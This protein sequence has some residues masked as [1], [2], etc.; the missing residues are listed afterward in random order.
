MRLLRRGGRRA[1][2][3]ETFAETNIPRARFGVLYLSR[4]MFHRVALTGDARD[5]ADAGSGEPGR[6]GQ[7][8]R[9][10]DAQEGGVK[11]VRRSGRAT[12]PRGRLAIRGASRARRRVEDIAAFETLFKALADRTRLRILGLLAGGGEVCVCDI[13]ESLRI[14]Q[15]RASRHLAYLRR[16][17]LVEARRRG[18]WVHYRLAPLADTVAATMLQMIAHGLGHL[19][20]VVLDRQRLERR[21]GC[22]PPLGAAPPGGLP[23]CGPLSSE[24]TLAGT[25]AAPPAPSP[26]SSPAASA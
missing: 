22:C 6:A 16:A 11:T 10:R 17:G 4:R 24:P 8:S 21:T 26:A 3:H 7:M 25:G 2:S 14:P 5:G 13:H 18:L 20:A 12:R 9:A 19:R 23:C 1:G 15:P